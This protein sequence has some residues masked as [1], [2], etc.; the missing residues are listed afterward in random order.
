MAE[1]DAIVVGSGM[2]G[3][4]A[5]KELSERGLKVL[6]LERG[7]EVVPERDYKDL[8]A[9]WDRPNLDRMPEDY[10][11]KH[12][13]RQ[14]EK[15]R[16][17]RT[18]SGNQFWVKDDEHPYETA[19]GTE[20]DW[21]RGYHTGGRSV[22]WGRQSYRLSP[23][24]FEQN[25]KDGHGVD[26][27]VRYDDIKPWY[28]H[29]E[30]FAG[31]S[32][33]NDGLEQLPDSIFQPPFEMTGPEKVLKEAV[34]KKFPGR[35]VINARVAH[36]TEPTEEQMALGRNQCQ[37]RNQ[38]Y[39]G[40]SFKA[41]FSS[42]HATLP[43]AMNT[44]NCTIKND[45]IVASLEYDADQKRVS[46]VNVIDQKT[47]ETSRHTAKI[48]FLNASAI[49]SAMILLQSKSDAFQNGLANASGQ[50]GMNL[51]DHVAGGG[52]SGI[53]PNFDDKTLYGR[54]PGGI[55][56]P[57]YG[58]LKEQDRPYLR[59]FGYQGGSRPLS[60]NFM[61]EQGIGVAFKEGHKQPA[62][63]GI[64]I[65]TFGEVLPNPD[66]KVML[67]PTK[68]DKWGLP[69]ALFDAKMGENEKLM[70][71]ESTKDAVEMLEAAGCVS[72][73]AR[74]VDPTPMGNRIHEMGTA[75]MGRDPKTSVLNGWN[76]AHDVPNLFVTDGAFMTSAG[77]QNP[78][79]TYMAFSARAANHAADLL[80]AGKL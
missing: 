80:Q 18:A 59:G 52:A 26:W 19:E 24:D 54:R 76:Q 40:C 30:K 50:V 10:I 27:P 37:V 53:M 9:P 44:G 79:L 20:F 74:K 3:G 1:F 66:N 39:Q 34:E 69:L 25:L 60:A 48:V 64:N 6:V 67:H 8:D 12:Q 28:E 47:G 4:W 7:K 63:W 68:K 17:P 45:A 65:G 57:R 70:L 31:I 61:K 43:A 35:N 62:A 22:T 55:Y 77:C 51:L 36:L 78:S 23:M 15:L 13:F 11:K 72:V 49:G 16:Q 42:L 32:G 14:A 58:N 71:E 33:N 46:A 56:I 21:Y 2:S 38:C 41:Y 73:R 29:V 5:A 75:R